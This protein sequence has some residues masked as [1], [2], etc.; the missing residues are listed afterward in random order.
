MSPDFVWLPVHVFRVQV[1]LL[2]SATVRGNF[3][4]AQVLEH[5]ITNPETGVRARAGRVAIFL[6]VKAIGD[7]EASMALKNLGIGSQSSGSKTW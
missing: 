1:A 6:H 3:P 2:A 7:C 4:L 5:L